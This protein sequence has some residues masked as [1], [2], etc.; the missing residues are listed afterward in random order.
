MSVFVNA[1]IAL[2]EVS[3]QSVTVSSIA[4]KHHTITLSN[5]K[6]TPLC[7]INVLVIVLFVEVESLLADMP[8]LTVDFFVIK[9]TSMWKKLKDLSE[10]GNY[11]IILVYDLLCMTCMTAVGKRVG[12]IDG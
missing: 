12:R 7:I 8:K 2:N 3:T 10:G 1:I 11:D 5:T 4:S 6:M 9:V